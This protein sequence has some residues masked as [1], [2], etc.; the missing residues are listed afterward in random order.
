MSLKAVHLIF[1]TALS[2]LGVGCGVWKIVDYAS[3][4]GR[5]VD[6]A[7]GIAAILAGVL[8]V[9]YGVYFLKKLK[10]INYL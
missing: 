6:L 4:A 10:S 9:V 7:Y 1:V 3:P 8:V 2:A 5:P